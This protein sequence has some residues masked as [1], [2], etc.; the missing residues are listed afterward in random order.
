MWEQRE[1]ETS[2]YL[3]NQLGTKIRRWLGRIETCAHPLRTQEL[4][5]GPVVNLLEQKQSLYG[6]FTKNRE[7][8]HKPGDVAR[9]GPRKAGTSGN[10]LDRHRE[11]TLQG[12]GSKGG[13][14]AALRGAAQ[15]CP[16]VMWALLLAPQLGPKIWR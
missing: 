13:C 11:P 2:W 9:N 1:K 3:C 16:P 12:R 7:N 6:D 8:K 15:I 10:D 4:I 5:T 14:G